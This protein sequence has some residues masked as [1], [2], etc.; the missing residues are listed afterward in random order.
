MNLLEIIEL[1]LVGADRDIVEENLKNLVNSLAEEE[2]VRK[3]KIY[4]RFRVDT[5][6]SIH[7]FHGQ[8]K[9]KNGGSQLGLRITSR[10]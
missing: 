7:L 3:I 10:H 2:E 5:D 1:R 9:V 4:N 8:F 6:F